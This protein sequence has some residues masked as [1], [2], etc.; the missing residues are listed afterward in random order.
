MVNAENMNSFTLKIL[1]REEGPYSGIQIAHMFAD[2]LVNR[3]TLCKPVE[4]NIWKTVDD[5]F[6]LLKYGAEMVAPTLQTSASIA[7][8]TAALPESSS[9]R[10][11]IVDFDIPFGSVLKIMFKWV[12]AGFIVA[13]C[14]IPAIIAVWVIV[15]AILAALLGG[16]MS[17]AHH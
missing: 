4:S 14:F 16:A 2:G 5:F 10:V 6:P 1:G 12:A 9:Q 13:C 3:G 7:A 17:N 11:A 8:R 15:M